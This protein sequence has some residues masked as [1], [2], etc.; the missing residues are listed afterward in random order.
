MLMTELL[1][2]NAAYYIT[3]TAT[4]MSLAV[5]QFQTSITPPVG[6]GFKIAQRTMYTIAGMPERK[7]V[8][9]AT[10]HRNPVLFKSSVCASPAHTPAITFSS[11]LL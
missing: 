2:H 9:N 4:P 6:R 7:S 5:R 1:F 3:F 8:T 11:L 10:I